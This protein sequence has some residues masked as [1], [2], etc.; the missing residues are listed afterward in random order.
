MVDR[1]SFF[2]KL[3][4]AILAPFLPIPK[5][6]SI[7]IPIES[8]PVYAGTRKLKTSWSVELE[9][10]LMMLYGINLQDE[11]TNGELV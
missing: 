10:D 3:I 11:L 9:Q 6:E 8:I 5:S 7:T 4:G 2:K 1:R